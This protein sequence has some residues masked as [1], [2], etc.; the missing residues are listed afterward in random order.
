MDF[1]LISDHPLK[2]QIIEKLITGVPAREVQDWLKLKYPDDNQK[3]LIVPYTVLE[4]F[5]QS[6]YIEIYNQFKKD[7][8]TVQDK[9]NKPAS[10]V[11]TKN[12]KETLET[13]ANKEMNILETLANLVKIAQVRLEQVFDKISQNPENTRNDKNLMGWVQ[14]ISTTVEKL[15]RLRI[16]AIDPLTQHNV[17]MAMVD[18]HIAIFQDAIRETLNEIDPAASSIFWEKLNSK[19]NEIKVDKELTQDERLK[20]ATVLQERLL[21]D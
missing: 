13:I 14:T 4:Q 2:E 10:L 1:S 11:G 8:N 5:S 12:Y 15:E 21:T 18:K 17:T 16:Q 19:L 3:H 20:E 7:L 6:Q 9:K